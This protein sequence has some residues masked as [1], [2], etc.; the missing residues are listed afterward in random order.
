M[1]KTLLLMLMITLVAE[2]KPATAQKRPVKKTSSPVKLAKPVAAN[3]NP[4]PN[5]AGG[6]NTLSYTIEEQNGNKKDM[7]I[8][9]APRAVNEQSGYFNTARVDQKHTND[10]GE[11]DPVLKIDINNEKDQNLSASMIIPIVNDTGT[12]IS[13]YQTSY[14]NI[15]SWVC[16]FNGYR[17]GAR[18]ITITITKWAAVGD[19]MEGTFSGTALLAD[20]NKMYDNDNPAPTVNIKN[21]K[22]RI[23][24]VKDQTSYGGE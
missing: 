24:R 2:I 10:K 21:G 12:V 5:V 7:L 13:T 11:K 16:S 17:L 6:L 14:D 9:S 3:N 22:F 18:A 19:F 15:I 4:K 20:I 1:K 23:K 8:T